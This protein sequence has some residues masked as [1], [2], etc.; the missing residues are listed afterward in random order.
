MF[1]LSWRCVAQVYEFLM[2]AVTFTR[3]S[4]DCRQLT[5]S[6]SALPWSNPIVSR[7]ATVTGFSCCFCNHCLGLPQ[8]FP[9]HTFGGGASRLVPWISLQSGIQIFD[10][11][12][13]GSLSPGVC[14]SIFASADLS[15]FP[16][17]FPPKLQSMG[18]RKRFVRS[19]L[20]STHTFLFPARFFES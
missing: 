8:A 1:F 11:A 12:A 13:A 14:G 18:S 10:S 19:W 7:H 5:L 20:V 16:P 3:K 6:L 4:I 2:L 17:S 15:L 9:C